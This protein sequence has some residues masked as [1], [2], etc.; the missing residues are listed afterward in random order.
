MGL[1]LVWTT[2]LRPEEKPAFEATV[3]NATIA[4]GRLREILH[5]R[6]DEIERQELTNDFYT[7][8]NLEAMFHRNIG[9]KKEL[10]DLLT[11]L[12]FKKEA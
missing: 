4:L 11:I 12:E 3:R 10:Y 2:N 5:S 8:I 7:N 9:R 1:P 6:L